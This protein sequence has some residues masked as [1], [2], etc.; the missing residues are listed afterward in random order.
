MSV[1][2]TVEVEV[3]AMVCANKVTAADCAVLFTS[4]RLIVG[5]VLSVEGVPQATNNIIIAKDIIDTRFEIFINAC[6]VF[7]IINPASINR[8]LFLF[9]ASHLLFPLPASVPQVGARRCNW[10][11]CSSDMRPLRESRSTRL[12]ACQAWAN[13]R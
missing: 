7:S 2:I 6:A 5:D 8:P 9:A 11:T 4:V 13:L 10:T 3:G 1:G 12:L